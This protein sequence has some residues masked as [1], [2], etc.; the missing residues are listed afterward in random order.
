ML[1][2]WSGLAVCGWLVVAATGAP[3]PVRAAPSTLPYELVSSKP[4]ERGKV[5]RYAGFAWRFVDENGFY[6]VVMSS[7]E[8]TLKI[9]PG[10]WQFNIPGYTAAD[11]VETCIAYASVKRRPGA[12]LESLQAQ[13]RAMLTPGSPYDKIAA[14]ELDRIETRT[15]TTLYAS[16]GRQGLTLPVWFGPKGPGVYKAVAILPAPAGTILLTCTNTSGQLAL[17]QLTALFKIGDAVL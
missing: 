17:N 15:T 7:A 8:R 9:R 14:G 13:T 3:A 2:K 12:T 6:A 11:R 1:M 5:S 10:A 16:T 4:E